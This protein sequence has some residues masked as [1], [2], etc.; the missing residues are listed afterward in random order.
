MS[1][2]HSR[3]VGGRTI[4]HITDSEAILTLVSGPVSLA[5]FLR[6]GSESAFDWRKQATPQYELYA[7]F[8][9]L[10]SSSSALAAAA[11][12]QKWIKRNEDSLF[13]NSAP[14]F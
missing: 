8:S 10:V 4:F 12:I 13:I 9:P 3:E 7:A 5:C 2:L 6:S 1:K 14:V 11:E